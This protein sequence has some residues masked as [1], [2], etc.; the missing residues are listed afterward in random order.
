MKEKK[1]IILF[2]PSGWKAER[3]HDKEAKP[4]T[5]RQALWLVWLY[6]R[7]MPSGNGNGGVLS[8]SARVFR[9]AITLSLKPSQLPSLK[10]TDRTYRPRLKEGSVMSVEDWVE[11]WTRFNRTV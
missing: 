4:L 10:P 7:Y 6:V 11:E 3:I 5:W 9:K 8:R 1:Y 2:D